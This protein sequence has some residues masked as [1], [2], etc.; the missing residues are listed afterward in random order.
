MY[1]GS[2]NVNKH[3]SRCTVNIWAHLPLSGDE[4]MYKTNR[5]CNL[6]YGYM[7]VITEAIAWI[8]ILDRVGVMGILKCQPNVFLDFL[9]QLPDEQESMAAN[10]HAGQMASPLS[11]TAGGSYMGGNHFMTS[12]GDRFIKVIYCAM[13]LFAQGETDSCH[14]TCFLSLWVVL[15]LHVLEGRM[16]FYS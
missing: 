13:L 9:W 14:W 6:R 8:E 7:C 15:K 3:H 2:S 10:L 16:V 1:S 4:I 5:V 12:C 11:K